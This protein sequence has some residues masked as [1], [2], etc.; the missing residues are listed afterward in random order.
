MSS[1]RDRSHCHKLLTLMQ[2]NC[3]STKILFPAAAVL[4]LASNIVLS[5]TRIELAPEYFYWQEDLHGAKVLDEKGFRIGLE[6]SYKEPV[7]KGWLGAFRAKIY[8]GEVD[9]NG[10]EQN[11]QTGA[12]QPL[13]ST[14]TYVGGLIDGRFGYR[15]NL[16]EAQNLDFLAGPGVEFWWR[17]LQAASGYDE[18]WIPLYVRAG[19]DLSPSQDAGWL[20]AL[21]AKVPVYTTQFADLDKFGLGW[22]TLHPKP[23]VSGYAELGYQ[24]TRGLTLAAFFDSYWFKQS[25]PGDFGV[26]QPESKTYQVGLKVG[27]TF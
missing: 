25:A 24:F 1:I 13:K 26:F 22:I 10:F 17:G 11:L 14:T 18:Y 12:L 8:G 23:M 15:W 7:K 5:Q 27:W 20:A 21:G 2:K 4:L 16:G 6:F 9:Y 19:F 3:A